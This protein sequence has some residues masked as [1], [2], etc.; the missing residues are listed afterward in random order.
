MSFE[1]LSGPGVD[2][3]FSLDRVVSSSCAVSGNLMTSCAGS[4]SSVVVRALC[5]SSSA[6][7]IFSWLKFSWPGLW[8]CLRRTFAASFPV[9]SR[10]LVPGLQELLYNHDLHLGPPAICPQFTAHFFKIQTLRLF[11]PTLADSFIGF[12]SEFGRSF[13]RIYFCYHLW[14]IPPLLIW[15]LTPLHS[16]SV[17]PPTS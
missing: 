12:N 3:D 11:V 8:Y 16:G 13:L 6:A 9:I 7:V 15:L 10:H 17:V 4:F 2:F 14:D 5:T 1:T